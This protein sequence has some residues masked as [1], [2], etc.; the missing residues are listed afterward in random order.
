MIYSIALVAEAASQMLKTAADLVKRR[1]DL[2][3][4]GLEVFQVE[5]ISTTGIGLSTLIVINSERTEVKGYGPDTSSDEIKKGIGVITTRKIIQLP[6]DDL[7]LQ[8][9]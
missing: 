5:L 1:E 7:E 4:P 2:E 8:I 6:T 9:V 3:S